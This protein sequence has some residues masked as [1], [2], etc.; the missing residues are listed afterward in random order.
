MGELPFIGGNVSLNPED[1]GSSFAFSNYDYDT[2]EQKTKAIDLPGL[3]LGGLLGPQDDSRIE[4]KQDDDGKEL[5]EHLGSVLWRQLQDVA[6]ADVI[7]IMEHITVQLV[8]LV[9]SPGGAEHP[10]GDL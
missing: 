10:L 2:Q 6:L 7:G 3:R 1:K 8:E 4:Q 5:G 9:P